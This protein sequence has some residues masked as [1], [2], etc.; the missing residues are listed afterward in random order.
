MLPNLIFNCAVRPSSPAP[1][2]GEPLAKEQ[3]CSQ[4]INN[5]KRLG[6]WCQVERFVIF[7]EVK[8]MDEITY[9]STIMELENFIQFDA[10]VLSNSLV[11]FAY[12]LEE[13][14]NKQDQLKNVVSQLLMLIEVYKRQRK[15]IS[16]SEVCTELSMLRQRF[17]YT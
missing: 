7:R 12:D 8:I 10:D 9:R 14:I 17:P 16:T 13:A 5:I 2:A 1:E 4:F 6:F 3:F 15:K 11:D